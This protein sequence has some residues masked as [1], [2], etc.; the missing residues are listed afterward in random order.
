M[1]Q[2]ARKTLDRPAIEV[3]AVYNMAEAALVVGV[4][5]GTVW[6]AI[7]SGRLKHCRV[8]RRVIIRGDQIADFLRQSEVDQAA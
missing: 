2:N 6:R 8:G 7:Q 3:G 1:E 5:W 4:S